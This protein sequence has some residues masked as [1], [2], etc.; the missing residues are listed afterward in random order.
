MEIFMTAFDR[1]WDLVKGF[2]EGFRVHGFDLDAPA[3]TEA[4]NMP[5][6]PRLK[7]HKI[8]WHDLNTNRNTGTG[9]TGT[10]YHAGPFD[11]LWSLKHEKDLLELQQRLRDGKGDIYVH[12]PT[13]KNPLITSPS[14][15]QASMGLLHN[16]LAADTGKKVMSPSRFRDGY[17]QNA[18]PI[19]HKPNWLELMG[20]TPEHIASILMRP[21][22]E[23]GTYWSNFETLPNRD[24]KLPEG[25]LPSYMTQDLYHYLQDSPIVRRHGVDGYDFFG[26]WTT[27]PDIL[28]DLGQRMKSTGGLSPMNVLLS[29]M[30]HDAVVP[31]LPND[32]GSPSGEREINQGSVLLPPAEDEWWEGYHPMESGEFEPL[33]PDHVDKF[34]DDFR[35]QKDILTERFPARMRGGN[36]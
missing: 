31:W 26:D 24:I 23:R 36:N 28:E 3:V 13:P 16:V 10:Y 34:I 25:A 20:D 32:R 18:W 21:Y 4:V 27:N 19:V 1:A 8:N 29:D 7:G 22:S 6:N 17:W 9:V 30:G 2:G 15:R 14:F 11:P 5:T 33:T 12:I 35:T